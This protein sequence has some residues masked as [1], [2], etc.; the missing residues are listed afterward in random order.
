MLRD[1][2]LNN[3]KSQHLHS[4]GIIRRELLQVGFSGLFGLGMG[5]LGFTASLNTKKPKSVILVFLTGA[6]SHIDMFDMKPDAP[7]EIR[8][9]FKPISTNVSGIQ[10]SEHLP[11][12]AMRANKYALVRSMSHKE[13]NHL[14]ATHHT[15]TGHQQPGGFFDKVASRDDWPSFSSALDYL[16]P[17]SD[18]IPSGINLPTFLLEG[19]LTWP[20]QH[21][22]FLG[23]RHDPW[24]INQD[25][26]KPDFK[27]DNVSLFP[28]IA[29]DRVNERNLLLKQVN[30]QQKNLES[31]ASTKRLAH[32]Q[33]LA[34]SVLASGK[35]AK[36]FDLNL[37]PLAGRNRYGN[38]SFG[39]SLLL[40]RRLSQAGVPVVQANMGRVQNWDTHGNNFNRLKN[41][42]LPPLDRGVSCLLDDL[43]STGLLEETMVRDT[44][45]Y[46]RTPK[47]RGNGRDHWAACYTTLFAGAGT[48][49]VVA[50]GTSLLPQVQDLA[51]QA[52]KK[53]KPERGGGYELSEHVKR[54]YKTTLV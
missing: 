13:N 50:A 10:I 35:I 2:A 44:G 21:A 45:E 48:V 4:T 26:A 6:S 12:L 36:A 25:P 54:Y 11:M 24:Q 20:G 38:H 5:N 40:A 27:V 28:G 3:Q 39:Q 31:I 29:I 32:Q 23:P 1:P 43:E 17:R 33:E 14:V 7:V 42:L 19:P 15:I 8:G 30:D 37:E 34:L 22:G 53:A 46:G 41:E 49:G 9:E 51:P 47:K 16:R 52:I 18:G